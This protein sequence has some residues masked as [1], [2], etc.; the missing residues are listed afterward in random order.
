LV[1]GGGV[2]FRVPLIPR[3][4]WQR[5]GGKKVVRYSCAIVYRFRHHETF[6]ELPFVTEAAVQALRA[7]PAYRVAKR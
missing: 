7:H 5:R 1:V 2:G 6:H 4:F 3:M